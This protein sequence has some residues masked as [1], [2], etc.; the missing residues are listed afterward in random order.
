MKRSTFCT[1]ALSLLAAACNKDGVL[2]EQIEPAPVIELD[3]DTGIYT[4]KVGRELTIAPT[5]LHADDAHY[6]WTANGELLS[7]EPVLRY[8][9]DRAQEL[10]LD[11]QVATPAGSAGEE[12][13]V[14]VL[15]L[16]P[17]AIS[18]IV[19]PK[20][21]KALPD[22]DYILAPDIRNDDLDDFRIEWLRDGVV[23]CT[24]RS[25]TF[26]DTEPGT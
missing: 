20:G 16:A 25:Y 7:S 2:T 26:R 18:L 21:L 1:L 10:Y 14:E 13:K 11:L 12:L 15:E 17:P 24:E 6:A 19:P 5:Y 8:T 23:V 22:T 9:W 3:S 4:V